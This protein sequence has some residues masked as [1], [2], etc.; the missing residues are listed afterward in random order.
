[1]IDFFGFSYMKQLKD[2][3]ANYYGYSDFLIEKFLQM[4]TVSEVIEFL[5]ANENA[6]PS[7]IRTNTLKTRR[8]DLAQ[9][10]INRGVNL[11]FIKWSK[12]GIQ[13]FESRVPLGLKKKK[14]ISGE[15]VVIN[16]W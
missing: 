14:R 15:K 6:R 7:T 12:V 8:R 9:S 16:I 4:F 1:M 10:L 3:L 5:K 2:D 13:I 11:E